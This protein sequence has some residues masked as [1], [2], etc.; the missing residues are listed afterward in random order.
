[1][2]TLYDAPT[3]YFFF[4]YY[5]KYIARKKLLVQL[6]SHSKKPR[7]RRRALN[8]GG[9]C[10]GRDRDVS[11]TRPDHD[12]AP[13][14]TVAAIHTW[15]L[16]WDQRGLRSLRVLYRYILQLLFIRSIFFRTSADCAALALLYNI[17]KLVS[18]SL[19]YSAQSVGL[20]IKTLYDAPTLYFFFTYYLQ[21]IAR[22]SS[23]FSYRYIIIRL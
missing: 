4:A 1:M 9:I 20:R 19:R 14:H 11:R 15:Y 17:R 13:P 21:Y 8:R 18:H 5:L 12:T 16:L 2:K 6:S 3:L 22:K 10:Y 7:N 23:Q